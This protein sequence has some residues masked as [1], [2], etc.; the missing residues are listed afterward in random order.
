[1]KRQRDKRLPLGAACVIAAILT[2]CGATQW[3]GD[4]HTAQKLER[5]QAQARSAAV[6]CYAVEGRYPRTLSYL[7]EAYGLR[8]D[9]ARYAVYYDA[10]ASNVPPDIDVRVIGEE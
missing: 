2:A 3:A 9:K 6:T 4:R 10:F 5:L 7:E 8:Y 1:M